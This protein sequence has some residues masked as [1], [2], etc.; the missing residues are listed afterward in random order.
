MNEKKIIALG[1]F[2]GVH[3]AH[4]ALLTACRKLADEMGCAAT[5]VTFTS[6]PDTL[7]RGKPPGLINTPADR[8][9]LM[10]ELYGLDSVIFLPFDRNMMTMPWQGFFRMLTTK[11]GAA[12]LVCGHDLRFGNRGEGNPRLLQAACE[13]EGIPCIVIPEQKIDGITISSTY[14]RTLIEEGQ[15]ERAAEFL[16][17]PHC[18]TGFVVPGR[19]LGRTIGVPTAN[20]CLPNDLAQPKRGVYACRCI[21]EGKSYCAVTNVGCRPTVSGTNLTVE[22]WILDFEGDLYGKPI[23]LEFHKYLRSERKFDSLE[24]LRA[25][26][27]K[28][29]LQTRDFFGK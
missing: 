21:I 12:G 25:E 13:K 2:D 16:G 7:V 18:F 27:Q 3:R 29:A 4:G 10:K 17:H 28:N 20:L 1:F 19:H 24:E 8:E 6:H 14:I 26:I 5:A 22:P 23:T 11:Y 15:M 9:R